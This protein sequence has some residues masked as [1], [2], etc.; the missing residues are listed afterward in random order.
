MN[1]FYLTVLSLVIST[2]Y[3]FA[4]NNSKIIEIKI[5]GTQESEISTLG[6]GKVADE[7]RE[8][9]MRTTLE[10]LNKKI[11]NGNF[12]FSSE[13]KIVYKKGLNRLS[14]LKISKKETQQIIEDNSVVKVRVE[15]A[16]N[17]TNGGFIVDNTSSRATIYVYVAIFNNQGKRIKFFKG[18]HK[19]GVVFLG[20]NSHKNR[21]ITKE[22]FII[23]YTSSLEE[24][25]EK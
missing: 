7:F 13:C 9:L 11:E 4:Q 2:S 24:L 1:K 3:L 6:K 19:D 23:G 22:D 20:K 16:F 8:T 21:W 12:V 17:E 5:E 10:I 18:K 25:E 14:K 15:I